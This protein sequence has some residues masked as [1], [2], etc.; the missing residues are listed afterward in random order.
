MKGGK[1]YESM[2]V[3]DQLREGLK[4]GIAQARGE[5][6]LDTT[7]LP[8][9]APTLSKSK[10]TAIRK[11]VGMSQAVFASYLNVPKK[12]LQS[13]EQGARTPKASEARLLQMFAIAPQAL[14]SLV[15]QAGRRSPASRRLQR[16]KPAR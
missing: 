11:K 13:W 14:E 1:N 6:R 9:P 16:R 5:L 3:F 10:V 15:S 8:A 7:T 4:D 2:S 12:T